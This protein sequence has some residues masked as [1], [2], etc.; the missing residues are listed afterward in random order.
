VNRVAVATCAGVDIDPDEPILLRALAEAGVTA[1]SAVW[2]DP[3]VEWN[4]FDLVVI[5][6]TW[7]YASR[8]D[9]FLA[10]AGSVERLANPYPVVEYSSDK[11]YLGDLGRR[12]HRVVATTFV[13]VGDEPSFP[14]GDFVV[15]PCVGAG[16]IDVE[17]YR[18]D[19]HERARA[20]V[21][22]LHAEGR[23]VIVQ[24]YVDTVD[25]VGERALVYLDGSFS[26]AVTKGAMLNV[27]ASDR[28]ARYRR[29]QLS[30]AQAELGAVEVGEAVLAGSG[31]ADLLYARLDLVRTPAG[32]AI[33]ELELV[34]PSL[35]L[36]FDDAAAT[37][38]AEAIKRRVE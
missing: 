17:R 22:R 30:P 13:D 24:P 16:S 27:T 7:D 9:E 32:W 4:R 2:D 6:S 34:E 14:G 28:D 36:A 37:R 19:E 23:D 12:G 10:W 29:E 8:R 15:K 5:R 38:L 35:F 18:P 20:H 31:F 26:H 11:H 33:M 25:Q 1:Q 3:S 21:A